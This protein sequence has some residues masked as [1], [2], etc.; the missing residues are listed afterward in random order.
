MREL[1]LRA[2][3]G[4][5]DAFERLAA[6]SVRRLHGVAR[7]MLRDPEAARDAVQEALI[8]VWRGLPT[9][10]DP[11]AFDAWAHRILVRSC[12]RSVRARRSRV[13]EVAQLDA[14]PSV[15]SAEGRIGDRDEIE[16]AFRRLTVDQR[17]VLV[18]YH[19]AGMSIDEAASVL[20]IPAGTMKSRLSRATAALR[21]S[22][23]AD[24][25]AAAAPKA[26]LA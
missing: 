12:Y 3:G 2:Q 25:R 13:V 15:A 16:R 5:H 1:V 26:R 24:E 18:L 8:E 19:Y 11:D 6:A 21:A 22:I 10:R 9:L 7:L 4:D 20:G 17:A 23:D 14:E